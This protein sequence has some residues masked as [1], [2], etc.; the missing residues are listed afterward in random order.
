MSPIA[1]K[2][3]Y[4]QNF[5][6][7]PD[8]PQKIVRMAGVTKDMFVIEI[9]PGKGIMTKELV[10]EAFA[11][12]AVEIDTS[13]RDTLEQE[14]T[15]FP[16]VNVVYGDIMETDID[17][18]VTMFSEGRKALVVANI[19]YYIT[20]PLIMKLLYET[21]SVSGA[22][23]MVQKEVALRMTALPGTA[24][25]SAFTI[26]I[27]QKAKADKLFSV[28]RGCFFPVPKVDSAVVRLTVFDE[29]Q[30]IPKDEKLFNALVTASFMQRRKTFV[31]AA[32]SVADKAILTHILNICGLSP[33]IRGEAL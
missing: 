32:S 18:L 7:T 5:L 27:Q 17:K 22:V 30:F 13:L 20:S 4:G 31:N 21:H 16:N 6:T 14:L 8:I 3:K 24:D 2:K 28:K 25:Y 9:G 29:P 26:A 23:L 19:P 33:D 10:K 12:T 15:P 11:V 1:P